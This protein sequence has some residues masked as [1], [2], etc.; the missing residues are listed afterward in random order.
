[1]LDED[2][3]AGLEVWGVWVALLHKSHEGFIL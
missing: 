3:S 1:M 2:Q